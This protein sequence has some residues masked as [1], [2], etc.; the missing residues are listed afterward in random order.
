MPYT[1]LIDVNGV[2]GCRPGLSLCHPSMEL[3]LI[4]VNDVLI[5]GKKIS[6][7]NGEALP[8]NLEL[9]LLLICIP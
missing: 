9:V 3:A 4:K 7:E 2:D 1:V 5:F 8:I 6:E